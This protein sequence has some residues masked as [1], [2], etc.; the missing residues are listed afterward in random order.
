MNKITKILTKTKNLFSKHK[1]ASLIA[2]VGVLLLIASIA[3]LIGG[4][5]LGWD[6]A[7]FFTSPTFIL[8]IT[9]G[10]LILFACIYYVI[11]GRR[12]RW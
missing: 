6:F 1:T 2:T 5:T 7:S 11:I 3:I 12:N 9:I 8:V 4:S 10:V